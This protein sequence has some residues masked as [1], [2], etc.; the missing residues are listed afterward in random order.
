[1]RLIYSCCR[2]V[3]IQWSLVAHGAYLATQ[4]DVMARLRALSQVLKERASGLQSLLHLK[5]KLDMLSAQL[6]MRRSIQAASR[7]RAEAED[8]DDEEGVVYVEGQ[9]DDDWSSEE[10]AVAGASAIEG[11]SKRIRDPVFPT[12]SSN[13]PHLQTATPKSDPSA[14]QNESSEDNMPNG[15]VQEQDDESSDA[16]EMEDEGMFDVEAEE[17][18]DDSEEEVSSEEED[19]EPESESELS[20][21]DDESDVSDGVK[22]PNPSTLN[23]KR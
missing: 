9:E 14:S 2:K 5:G 20:E 7:A 19:S 4:P 3:W 10:D 16:E 6:D 17:T 8:E 13:R 23:R 11:G 15:V 18:D 1:M 12:A 22:A 21:D